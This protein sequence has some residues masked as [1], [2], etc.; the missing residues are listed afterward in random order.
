MTKRLL[1]MLTALALLAAGCA[2][3]PRPS[4][5]RLETLRDREAYETVHVVAPGET[6]R[7]IA[8]RY[9]GDPERALEIARRNGL[10]DPDR[11]SPGDELRLPLSEAEWRR[12]EDHRVA[13]ATYNEGVTHL[14]DGLVVEAEQ[15]FRRALAQDPELDDARYNLGLCLLRRGHNGQAEEIFRELVARTPDDVAVHAALG[16]SLFYQ[17][18]FDE[19]VVAFDAV[20]AL[21]P[22]D[23]DAA[24]SRASALGEA[25]RI[26]EAD[27][28]WNA[29]LRRHPHGRLAE[30]ARAALTAL[31][32]DE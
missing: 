27:T 1:L 19:A 7:V 30:R 28:A 3:R 12:A 4:S 14:R 13:L 24:F 25:G 21:D 5:E 26:A 23:A 6:L 31:H 22:S 17:A 8:D 15:A 9:Y 32:A 11:L 16:Q 29:F 2:H 18:R 20:L 10:V